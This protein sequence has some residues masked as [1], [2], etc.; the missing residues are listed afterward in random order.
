M[1]SLGSW[2]DMQEEEGACLQQPSLEEAKK[3]SG[4]LLVLA[5]PGEELVEEAAILAPPRTH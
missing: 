1:F 2:G 3:A 5:T 4:G